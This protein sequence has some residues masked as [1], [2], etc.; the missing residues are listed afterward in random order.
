[1]KR[2][3]IIGSLLGVALG[4]VLTSSIAHGVFT[5]GEATT[6]AP[7]GSQ[8]DLDQEQEATTFDGQPPLRPGSDRV[9]LPLEPRPSAEIPVALDA[10]VDADRPTV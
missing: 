5:Q 9:G 1:M 8:L 2:Q 7:M 4:G 6:P 10:Q 3:L